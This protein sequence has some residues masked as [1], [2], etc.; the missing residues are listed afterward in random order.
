MDPPEA[1][2][3]TMHGVSKFKQ[4]DLRIAKARKLQESQYEKDQNVFL[5]AIQDVEDAPDD[6]NDND[7]KDFERDLY[8]EIDDS[9]ALKRKEFVKKGLLKPNP[10]KDLEVKRLILS[11]FIC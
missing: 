1:P 7:K 8:S 3:D 9:I 4:L 11:L 6:D 2:E 5:K 10:K